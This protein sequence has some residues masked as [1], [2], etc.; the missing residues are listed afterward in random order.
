[1]SIQIDTEQALSAVLAQRWEQSVK[2]I[3]DLAEALPEDKLEYTPVKDARSCGSVLRH[4]AFWN[5]YVADA[6]RGNP[7]DDSGNELPSAE[8]STRQSVLDEIKRTSA[9][10]AVALRQQSGSASA[11]TAKLL[12]TFLEHTAEHYGQLVVYARM[13]NIVPPASRV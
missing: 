4:V 12:M 3:A 5:R 9:D 6:L 2:K 10:I 7:L 11:E 13:M 8:Y 1:M